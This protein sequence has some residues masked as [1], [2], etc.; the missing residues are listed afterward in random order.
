MSDGSAIAVLLNIL[1]P[2]FWIF[3]ILK[4]V[5]G[6]GFLPIF[7]TIKHFKTYLKPTT[8]S[9]FPQKASLCAQILSKT[10]IFRI[11]L[12]EQL[13]KPF[14]CAQPKIRLKSQCN[15]KKGLPHIPLPKST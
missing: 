1:N 5:R 3:R 7:V 12:R 14:A 2:K 13:L 10:W 6:S 11:L 15:P 4:G 9:G 8:A